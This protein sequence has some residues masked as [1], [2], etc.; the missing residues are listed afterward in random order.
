MSAVDDSGIDAVDLLARLV[1]HAKRAGGFRAVL[2]HEPKSAPGATPTVAFWVDSMDPV[3]SGLDEVSVR[4]TITCRVYAVMLGEPGDGIDIDLLNAA[5]R[6]FRAY[7][8][9]FTLGGTARMIDIMGAE[10][11]SLAMRA[12]YISIDSKLFRVFNI[13]IPVILNDVFAEEA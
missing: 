3:T 7:A 12:G 1:S 11:V 10:G 5:G 8:G 13:T 6:L 2:G 9:G 4:V